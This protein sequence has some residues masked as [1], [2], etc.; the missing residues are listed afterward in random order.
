M[1]ISAQAPARA[2]LAG[3]THK[4]AKR[5]DPSPCEECW[6]GFP[7]RCTSCPDGLVHAI[8]GD[9]AELMTRGGISISYICSHCEKPSFNEASLYG[10]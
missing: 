8:H 4:M 6:P 5:L 1:R 10:V 7:A 9:P 3:H 2:P